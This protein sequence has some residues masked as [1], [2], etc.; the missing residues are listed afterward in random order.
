MQSSQADAATVTLRNPP[1]PV[2]TGAAVQAL[3]AHYG[4]RAEVSPLRGER[5]TNFLVHIDGQPSHV[6]RVANSHE[7]RV[8]ADFRAAELT[9]LERHAPDL[10]VPRIQPT[11]D[12]RH[13]F[14]WAHSGWSRFAQLV[15]YLPG[16]P[17]AATPGA[18]GTLR[19]LG[20]IAARMG[21]A[22]TGFDHEGA[23]L[24][25]LWDINQAGCAVSYARLIG[26]GEQ[27]ELV[28]WALEGFAE[29]QPVLA[30]LRHQVIHN[31]LNP[32][33]ILISDT[34]DV[35]GVIDF[36]D[37]VYSA[38]VNDVAVVCS[39]LT[40]NETEPLREI[41]EFLT[42][43][44]EINPLTVDE[45]AVLPKLIATRH[46]LTVIITNW[47][48]AM[49]PENASYIVRNQASSL[50]GLR[51]LSKLPPEQAAQRLL[52]AGRGSRS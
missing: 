6:L 44:C 52:I 26:D 33:N 2:D 47:R 14:E 16:T 27:A 19:Q 17:M 10:P 21:M 25:L 50:R 23:H 1:R 36:G 32:H 22:L 20:A 39:Y 24:P 3:A 29:V 49:F 37:S 46:A 4:V 9:Y 12:G 30:T 51:G 13:G 31:D 35:A 28:G 18:S 15:T 43:Y 5:D 34:N 48:A 45:L 38:L 11:R 7:A 8:I 41:S 42:A 40:F